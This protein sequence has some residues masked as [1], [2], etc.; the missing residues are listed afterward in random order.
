MRLTV[1]CENGRL[2]SDLAHGARVESPAWPQGKKTGLPEA[3]HGVCLVH[4]QINQLFRQ[5]SSVIA[6]VTVVRSLGDL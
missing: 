3:F 4:S 1:R 6:G 2:T 5:K